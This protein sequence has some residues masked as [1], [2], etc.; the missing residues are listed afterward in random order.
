M[1]C[2]G[3]DLATIHPMVI[4]ALTAH[5]L[6]L[7]LLL[8]PFCCYTYAPRHYDQWRLPCEIQARCFFARRADPTCVADSHGCTS[9][10]SGSPRRVLSSLLLCR[11]L[12][13]LAFG[14][15]LH[16]LSSFLLSCSIFCFVS[17]SGIM[18]FCPIFT[19]SVFGR[20]PP[21]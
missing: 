19:I 3:C 12:Q 6:L 14:R 8:L 9:I 15:V 13:S 7:L 5:L 2:S 18:F 17:L 1:G 21:L 10:A 11:S 16:L 4:V 20:L